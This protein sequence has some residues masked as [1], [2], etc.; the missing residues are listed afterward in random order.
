M[1]KRGL[2]RWRFR[3]QQVVA[4]SIVDFYC[5]E[6]RVA[7]EV[8]GGVHEGRR[9]EDARR[10]QDLDRV[11]VRVVRVRDGDVREALDGVLRALALWCET[12]AEQRGFRRHNGFRTPRKS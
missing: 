4:G 7:I 1:R 3:R 2:G 11:G 9:A 10:D 6:L 12:V 5:A 8:D